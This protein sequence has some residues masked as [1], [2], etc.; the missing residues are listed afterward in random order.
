MTFPAS[1]ENALRYSQLKP[2][3]NEISYNDSL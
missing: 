1:I 2:F 3:P